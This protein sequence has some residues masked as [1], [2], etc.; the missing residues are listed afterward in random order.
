M[1]KHQSTANTSLPQAPTRRPTNTYANYHAHVY[2]DQRS[3]NRAAALCAEAGQRFGVSVGRVHQK[4][5]G[6]H[7]RWSCQLTF[8]AAQFGQLIPWLEQERGELTVLVHP[9]TGD[10][11]QDHSQ[12]AMWLGA[13]VALDLSIFK[14]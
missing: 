7:P 11:L 12:H 10:D 4:T 5:V 9:L 1:R 13:P 6:P 3:V 14:A 8:D 2:F